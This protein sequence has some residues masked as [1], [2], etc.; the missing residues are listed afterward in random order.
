MSPTLATAV[1]VAGICGLLWMTWDR[2]ARPSW[3]LW[4]PLIWFGL[5]CSRT[6]TDWL[7]GSGGAQTA[8]QV[9]EGSPLDRAI[10]MGLLLGGIAVLSARPKVLGV[11][12]AN[13]PLLFFYFYCLVSI[14]WSDY[15][16]TALK[17][18]PKALGDVVMV[19][20]VLTDRH[21]LTAFRQLLTR[22]SFVLIPLSFL[23]IKYYPQIGMQWDPWTGTAEFNGVAANK[24]MLGAVCMV[25]G[26]GILWI[27]LSIWREEK[28]SARIRHLIAY[29]FIFALICVLF[30]KMN[31]MTSLSCFGMAGILLVVASRQ[32][33]TGRPALVHILLASMVVASVGILFLGMSPGALR[34]IGRNPTLT[35]R[36][37]IWHLTLR[38]VQHPLFGTGFESFW[39]GSRL[40]ALWR[41]DPVTRVNEAHNGYLEVYLNLGWIGIGLLGFI[42]ATG[43]RNVFKAW[44]S[45]DPRGPLLIA[46]FFAGLIYNFTE[47]AF[48]K[49]QAVMW[50]FF[51]FTLTRATLVRTPGTAAQGSSA[52]SSEKEAPSVV[53]A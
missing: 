33:A 20:L 29:G 30:G 24:N 12:W 41:F 16:A 3:A 50:L 2:S 51:L 25:L 48:F 5:A 22:L 39:L 11:L 4:I 1:C 9:L 14:I 45:R 26:L 17:R 44:Q 43:Y 40:E 32:R 31:S 19:L 15:P 10:F 47:A 18:W 8:D 38:L 21:P 35:D 37:F 36:T 6:V 52:E 23:F 27:L 28:G 46:Y 34:A 42:L 53:A 49:M 7:Y 13:R